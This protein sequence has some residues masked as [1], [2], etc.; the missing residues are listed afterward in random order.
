MPNHMK[1]KGSKAGTEK[2]EAGDENFALK[3]RDLR[4]EVY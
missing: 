2:R 4:D 3:I 1:R